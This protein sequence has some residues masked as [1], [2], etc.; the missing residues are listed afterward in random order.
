MVS[1]WFGSALRAVGEE[2][3]GTTVTFLFP[4]FPPQNSETRMPASIRKPCG[5][6][7]DMFVAACRQAQVEEWERKLLVFSRTLDEWLNCQRNWL[8]LEQIFSTPDIQRWVHP[9]CGRK[10]GSDSGGLSKEEFASPGVFFYPY[11]FSLSEAC[12]ALERTFVVRVT[13]RQFV[14]VYLMAL[15][16]CAACMCKKRGLSASMVKST[17]KRNGLLL[18]TGI[19]GFKF[20]RAPFRQ[21]NSWV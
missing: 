1:F 20:Q 21:W 16:S 15:L 6:A 11:R 17:L 18:L 5:I 13:Q 3:K 10:L 4:S 7:R 12:S 9:A 2:E 19:L 8:Y 14:L